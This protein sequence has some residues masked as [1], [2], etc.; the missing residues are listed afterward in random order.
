MFS[1]GLFESPVFVEGGF[2]PWENQDDFLFLL[3][4]PLT[5]DHNP[6]HSNSN[7][8]NSGSGSDEVTTTTTTTPPSPVVDER[9]QRRMVSN[10]E[11]A[12]RSRMRKQRHLEDLRNQVNRMRL[13]NRE[14]AN[15]LELMNHHCH[16]LKRDN[17]RLMSESSVLRQRL[18]DIRQ[19]LIFRH[20]QRL[21]SPLPLNTVNEQLPSLMA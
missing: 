8:N 16:I 10:R 17:D 7:S 1:S 20:L 2:T 4:Q 18:S 5:I 11:S 19:I 12:R 3:Q 9:K 13:D 14:V 21:P 6:V 15:R